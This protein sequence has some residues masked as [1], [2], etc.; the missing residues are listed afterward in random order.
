MLPLSGLLEVELSTI[1]DLAVA[2]SELKLQLQD[3]GVSYHDELLREALDAAKAGD[4]EPTTGGLS[5]A[6][7]AAAAFAVR[8]ARLPPAKPLV[9][10]GPGHKC[11]APATLLCGGC[12]AQYY[13]S[14]RCQRA[15]WQSGHSE[16]CAQKHLDAGASGAA[17]GGASGAGLPVPRGTTTSTL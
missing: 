16:E 11:A 14:A 8:H 7:D 3:K 9:C 4:F 6:A 13:C 17:G 2:I 10:S 15:H 1:A 5:A 12:D